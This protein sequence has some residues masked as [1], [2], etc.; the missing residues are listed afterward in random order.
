MQ[1][2]GHIRLLRSFKDWRYYSDPTTCRLFEHLLLSV[3]YTQSE[4]L[5]ITIGRGQLITTQAKLCAE[6]GLS[7]QQIRTALHKLS[8]AR[9]LTVSSNKVQTKFKQ[10]STLITILHYESYIEVQPI[11]N[12]QA[13]NEQPMNNQQVT[14]GKEE[15][16]PIPP[17]EESIKKAKKQKRNISKPTSDEV[18][19]SVSQTD[20]ADVTIVQ[21]IKFFNSELDKY[22][23]ALK[24]V[25]GGRLST[26]GKRYINLQARVKEFGVD[27]V[28]GVFS[29]AAQ[30]DFLNG[31]NRRNWM[32]TFD[33]LLKPTNF[34]KVLDGNYDNNPGH[35]VEQ[36]LSLEKAMEIGRRV[37]LR[38]GSEFG[39]EEDFWNI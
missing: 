33:W 1:Q 19:M 28:K 9:E 25:Q 8:V 36:P 12:Q 30:S 5:G 39:K 32:A 6:T 11:S 26:S 21:L 27:A 37:P 3:N 24:P 22:K 35:N 18:G 17:K 7:R 31:K 29:K 34:Q 13:T 10:S 4:Y 20:S 23:S 2:Q 15:I 38:N 14:N 16:S